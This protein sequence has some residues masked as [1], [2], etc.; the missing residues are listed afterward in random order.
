MAQANEWVFKPDE[1]V[2]TVWS[3]TPHD[4]LTLIIEE[5]DR[6]TKNVWS[7]TGR[8]FHDFSSA[9][10]WKSIHINGD[11]LHNYW[12]WTRTRPLHPRPENGG[13]VDFLIRGPAHQDSYQTWTLDQEV[14]ASPRTRIRHLDLDLGPLILRDGAP[15]T[16]QEL[17]IVLGF[18]ALFMTRL[19][20]LC[21]DGPLSQ[22]SLGQ[23][24][25]FESLRYLDLGR[26]RWLWHGLGYA[27]NAL[28]PGLRPVPLAKLALDFTCLSDMQSLNTLKIG[29]LVTLEAR[30]LAKA[31]HRLQRLTLLSISACYSITATRNG[32]WLTERPGGVSPLIPFLEALSSRGREANEWPGDGVPEGFPRYLQ[33]LTLEDPYY[34]NQPSL[35]RVL[36]SAI[37]PCEKL[38]NLTITFAYPAVAQNF[39]CSLGLPVQ[40]DG[41]IAC[42]EILHSVA[43]LEYSGSA[44]WN[45]A[46][47]I[48]LRDM[49]ESVEIRRSSEA[50][51]NE[52]S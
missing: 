33:T 43:G 29:R 38:P 28:A 36:Q 42:L 9:L 8:A 46:C 3:K 24:V 45:Q 27:V 41:K 22:G 6:A 48:K 52:V 13:I 51:S 30:G 34:F 16:N 17:E 15:V 21:F 31:V 20:L 18:F 7:R 11:D 37:K 44:A 12:D 40:Q 14:A 2:S 32:T 5:A 23:I 47:V 39:L 25:K 10:L 35:N 26:L 19:D 4:I 49:D 50:Y 1:L